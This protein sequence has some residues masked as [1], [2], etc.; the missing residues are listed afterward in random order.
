MSVEEDDERTK[1]VRRLRGE[2]KKVREMVQKTREEYRT[3]MK[4]LDTKYNAKFDFLE[5]QI[6]DIH[7]QF[8]E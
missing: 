7:R 5:Q 3:E 4:V 6:Q 2:L 8:P 1:T